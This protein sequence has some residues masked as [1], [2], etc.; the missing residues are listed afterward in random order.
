MAGF[1]VDFPDD[2]LSELTDYQFEVIAEPALKAAAPALEKSMKNAARAVVQHEGESEMVE[3]ITAGKPVK[4]KTDA[5]IVSVGP[6]GNSTHFYSKGSKK[7]KK[8]N[9]Y[10]VS[11]ALKGIWM[12][13]GIN[14][15]GHHQAP[16]PFL[17]KATKDAQED[18]LEKMQEV[19]DKLIK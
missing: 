7:K 5:Y 3:S 14:V 1:N 12:E 13:Y 16:R 10:P 4:T 15:P 17:G 9:K 6:K 18:V 8:R 2:F 19:Y 11:N